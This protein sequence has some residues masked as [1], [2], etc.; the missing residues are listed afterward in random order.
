MVHSRLDYA[1][2]VVHGQ[3]NVTL[4]SEQNSVT[5]VVLKNSRICIPEKNLFYMILFT[6][7]NIRF[8]LAKYTVK[9]FPSR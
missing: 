5:R 2:S 9:H 8:R 7:S 3:A 1:N 4:Q 6:Y